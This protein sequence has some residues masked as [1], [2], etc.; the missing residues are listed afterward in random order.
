MVV[1]HSEATIKDGSNRCM[2]HH[3]V[4]M[5]KN[6]IFTNALVHV[7][8]VQ[9]CRAHCRS[10]YTVFVRNCNSR[11]CTLHCMES[12]A[13]GDGRNKVTML[14]SMC[15]H[16]PVLQR[17]TLAVSF[18]WLFGF[19]VKRLPIYARFANDIYPLIKSI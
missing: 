4:P 19:I 9:H 11:P 2:C 6:E 16:H 7:Y 8:S 10:R 12:H 1:L 13:M 3:T 17:Q 5:S 15:S 18:Y 14:G